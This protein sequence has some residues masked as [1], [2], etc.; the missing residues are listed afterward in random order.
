[1]QTRRGDNL[2]PFL[3]QGTPQNVCCVVGRTS[4]SGS[5]FLPVRKQCVCLANMHRDYHITILGS[6][7]SDQAC[8]DGAVSE[9]I[10]IYLSLSLLPLRWHTAPYLKNT[11]TQ[12]TFHVIGMLR[13]RHPVNSSKLQ[14]GHIV[15]NNTKSL[16]EGDGP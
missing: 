3:L 6:C 4:S 2:H 5:S 8:F 9:Y 10:Y 13:N 14:P 16:L 15:Y 12:H 11:T 7:D 1:V